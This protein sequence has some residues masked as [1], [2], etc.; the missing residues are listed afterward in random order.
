M[1]ERFDK[2]ILCL[3]SD[4]F[5]LEDIISHWHGKNTIF[6]F[7]SKSEDPIFSY[8]NYDSNEILTNIDVVGFFIASIGVY[9]SNYKKN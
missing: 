2:P 9:I 7:L 1:K 8:V 6:T 5:Y 4:N 3:D